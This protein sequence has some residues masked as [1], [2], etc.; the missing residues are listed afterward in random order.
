VFGSNGLTKKRLVA[1]G[2]APSEACLNKPVEERFQELKEEG[3]DLKTIIIR[4]DNEEYNQREIAHVVRKNPKQIKAIVNGEDPSF[5]NETGNPLS[6]QSAN[7]NNVERN[8]SDSSSTKDDITDEDAKLLKEILEQ[9]SGINS[10]KTDKVVRFYQTRKEKFN[11][12]P[13]LIYNLLTG[14]GLSPYRAQGVL[15]NFLQ[16]TSNGEFEMMAPMMIAG[17]MVSPN[18]MIPMVLNRKTGKYE[19]TEEEDDP[20]MKKLAREDK[21]FA[22]QMMREDMEDRRAERKQQ[23]M[24]NQIMTMMMMKMMGEQQRGTQGALGAFGSSPMSAFMFPEIEYAVQ[25][26]KILTDD[27]GNPVPSRMRYVPM[28]AY[29]MGPN[30][31]QSVQSTST[32]AGYDKMFDVMGDALKSEREAKN[33]LVKT[34]AES[35]SKLSEQQTDFLK[36]RL[37]SLEQSDPI[38]TFVQLTSRLKELGFVEGGPK[39]ENVEVK[40]LQ[41]DLEKW[42]H[43][44]NTKLQQ[45]IWE[46]KQ[47]MKDKE[48]ARAQLKELGGSIR[49]GIEKLGVPLANGFADG[50]REGRL[51]STPRQQ[52]QGAKT[53]AQEQVVTQE[54]N[55]GSTT[56]PQETDLEKLNNDELVNTLGEAQKAEKVVENAKKQLVQEANRRGLKI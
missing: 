19:P 37:D 14:A 8:L 40:R 3:N 35:T 13:M 51:R 34:L 27:Y 15:T 9:T 31:N 49:T 48:Y 38:E 47:Q 45:W 33:D 23:K 11:E 53:P 56:Q 52:N 42:K 16:Y 30:H 50:L 24:M 43:E 41:I 25:D 28:T 6:K 12:N 46:Q 26:G 54:A 55:G 2:T 18:S 1:V 32:P 17:G 10:E 22:V 4:L 44:N 36:T 29:M 21:K 20:E 5:Q 7:G 39:T